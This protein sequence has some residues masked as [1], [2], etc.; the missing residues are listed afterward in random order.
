MIDEMMVK[1][2]SIVK[3]GIIYIEKTTHFFDHL[4]S[5]ENNNPYYDMGLD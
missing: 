1:L 4:E 5:P 3:E 2:A